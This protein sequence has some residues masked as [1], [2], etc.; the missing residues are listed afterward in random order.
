MNPF[1]AHDAPHRHA[2][3]AE[4]LNPHIPDWPF[5]TFWGPITFDSLGQNNG[6]AATTLQYP[7][8]ATNPDAPRAVVMY[9]SCDDGL[10]IKFLSSHVVSLKNS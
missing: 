5:E 9:V 3:T 10:Y 1:F 2:R 8:D 6:R 4:L 7:Y